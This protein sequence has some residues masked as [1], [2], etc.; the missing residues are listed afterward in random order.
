MTSRNNQTAGFTLLEMIVVI[1]VLGLIISMLASFGPPRDRWAQTQA[2][3]QRIA[4][5]MR[6]DGARAITSGRPVAL[7]LPPAPAWLAVT[8]LAPAGGIL[9]EPD[10]SATGGSVQLAEASRRLTVTADWLT[11]EARIDDQ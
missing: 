8:V 9:F 2:Q 11:G 10:G 3:A 7:V 5:T 1:A 4:A 6:E